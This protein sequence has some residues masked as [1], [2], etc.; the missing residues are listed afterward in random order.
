[1]CSAHFWKRIF[2]KMHLEK[3]TCVIFFWDQNLISRWTPQVVNTKNT[4]SAV[5]TSFQVAS[6]RDLCSKVHLQRI[7]YNTKT[8]ILNRNILENS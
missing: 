4:H 5:V 2:E 6:R 3:M 1:M 7:W 8:C